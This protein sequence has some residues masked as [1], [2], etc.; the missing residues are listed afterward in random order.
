EVDGGLHVVNEVT[1]AGVLVG[2]A[3]ESKLLAVGGSEDRQQVPDPG[4][5][6]RRGALEGGVAGLV[7]VARRGWV[8]DAPVDSSRVVGEVGTNFASL[9]AQSDH[10]VEP[11]GGESV[12]VPGLLIGDVNIERVAQHPNGV[13]V[14]AG[15]G[16]AAGAGDRYVLCG[17]VA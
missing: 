15:F 8:G 11:A 6:V 1:D 9:V 16:P 2:C 14:H 4:V 3:H 7:G 5:D 10:V 12:Q 13:G 17:V